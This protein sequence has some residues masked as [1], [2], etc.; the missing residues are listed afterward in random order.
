MGT[1]PR[2]KIKFTGC[3]MGRGLCEPR[4]SSS[5]CLLAYGV[6]PTA[7]RSDNR[8]SLFRPP[9]STP[10]GASLVVPLKDRV[11]YRPGGLHRILTSEQCSVACKGVA[12]EPLV[13]RFLSRPFLEQVELSLLPD[14]LLPGEFD[15][16]CDGDGRVG[17]DPEAQVVGRARSE[18]RCLW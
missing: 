16:S 14:E 5:G 7:V 18:E 12:Q 2:A 13:G 4:R 11:N 15:A 1:T 9:T 10:V 8:V 6:V 3:Q 17:R